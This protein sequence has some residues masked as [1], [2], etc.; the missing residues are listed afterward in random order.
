MAQQKVIDK[1][2]VNP[3]YDFNWFSDKFIYK[4]ISF[5]DALNNC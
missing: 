4:S 5:S 3:L 2:C 1:S